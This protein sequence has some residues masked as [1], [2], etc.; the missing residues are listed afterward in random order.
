MISFKVKDTGIG[1]PNRKLS[2]LFNFFGKLNES[3]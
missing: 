1:I 2:D 3:E